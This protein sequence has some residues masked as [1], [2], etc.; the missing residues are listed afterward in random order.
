MLS[1]LW[2]RI[3]FL[4]IGAHTKNV[5]KLQFP[6]VFACNVT[7]PNWSAT[8]VASL[9][10][11]LLS[12][13][14]LFLTVYSSS[15]VSIPLPLCPADILSLFSCLCLSCDCPAG[16]LRLPDCPSLSVYASSFTSSVLRLP[17]CLS[18]IFF[19]HASSCSSLP[20]LLLC[21]L[22]FFFVQS[23]SSVCSS[24]PCRCTQASSLR[25]PLL[26][27]LLL[28]FFVQSSSSMCS[29]LP[30]RCTQGQH[31]GQPS[32]ARSHQDLKH[33]TSMALEWDGRSVSRFAFW[34][35]LLD[36]ALPFDFP[37]KGCTAF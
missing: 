20:L 26:L 7:R 31:Q 21:P 9:S 15:S 18:L 27:C 10:P 28:S 12:C 25:L 34:T 37:I 36:S 5:V 24:L 33:M 2:L 4:A 23:S 13:L 3:N 16:L 11:P 14:C 29:C 8:Q 35:C 17:L 19:V 6:L 32:L 22:F 30:C 1:F